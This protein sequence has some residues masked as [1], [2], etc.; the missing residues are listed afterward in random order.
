MN[1]SPPYARPARPR[2]PLILTVGL[3]VAGAWLMARQLPAVS[4]GPPAEPRTVAP[5]GDLGEGERSTIALYEQASPSVVNITSVAHRRDFFG[6]NVFE[7]PQGTGSGFFWDSDGH[8]VTNYHVVKESDTV[9]ATLADGT[10]LEVTAAWIAPTWDLAVL[11]VD[12]P[13]QKLKPIPVGTSKD[14]R[15]GQRVFA[16]GNPFGLD[17]TLTTGIVSALGRTITSIGGRDI[18]GVIQTDAAINPGNSGG[19][20]LDSSGRLIGVNTAIYSTS[21]SSAG[22][23]F[24]VPVDIVNDIVPQL[25]QHGRVVRP[26]LGIQMVDD[27]LARRWGV[28]GVVVSRAVPGSGAETAGL[29]GMKRT[30]DGR[31]VLGDIIKKVDQY[32]ISS[33]IDLIEALENFEVGDTVEITFERDRQLHQTKIRLQAPPS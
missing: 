14:L 28:S 17:Q 32:A 21:G 26:H 27:R 10:V 7:I 16:I 13:D 8:I 20:L 5:R 6:R 23:G 15:V 29:R 33:G 31:L 25:I 2:G 18:E 4:S 22:I 3:L 19:P 11:R 30:R 9:H 24:A 12:V 1:G